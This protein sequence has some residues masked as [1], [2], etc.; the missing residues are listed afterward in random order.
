MLKNVFISSK[1]GEK[2][3]D[4]KKSLWHQLGR[5]PMNRLGRLPNINIAYVSEEPDN[6]RIVIS[7]SAYFEFEGLQE[8]DLEGEFQDGLSI[9]V[10]AM[11]LSSD[12]ELLLV[13]RK[14]TKGDFWS[15]PG[16]LAKYDDRIS[17]RTVQDGV[18]NEIGL[19]IGFI[20]SF[21]LYAYESVET[22]DDGLR[23]NLAFVY[24]HKALS[25]D[26][27]IKSEE[28]VEARWWKPSDF[29]IS[30]LRGEIKSLPNIKVLLKNWIEWNSPCNIHFEQCSDKHKESLE[31]VDDLLWNMITSWE[32]S[33]SLGQSDRYDDVFE[34]VKQ[35]YIRIKGLCI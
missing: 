15:I 7:N 1:D 5:P 19:G 6:K 26:I 20:R 31:N 28:I 2:P 24:N 10:Y 11:C 14:S 13:K 29:Y 8:E 21:P 18:F 32:G 22:T 27:E 33:S 34:R 25:R 17:F 9:G 30:Y 23:H 16:G 12:N 4:V 3:V 35:E